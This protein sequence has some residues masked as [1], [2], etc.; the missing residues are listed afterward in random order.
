MNYP[1]PSKGEIWILKPDPLRKIQI[2]SCNDDEQVVVKYKDL[3][4]PSLSRRPITY[5]TL[6]ES[7]FLE[8]SKVAPVVDESKLC[9]MKRGA[10]YRMRYPS[11]AERGRIVRLL[12]WDDQTIPGGGV[13][14]SDEGA[15]MKCQKDL[16]VFQFRRK[17]EMVCETLAQL[18]DYYIKGEPLVANEYITRGRPPAGHTR[19]ERDELAELRKRVKEQEAR[20]V[21]LEAIATG[22]VIPMNKKGRAG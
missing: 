8:G 17:W 15:E 3:G 9:F 5:R 10:C 21:R 4:R 14:Y 1:T 7:W 18:P 16:S 6:R 22:N 19:Q 20:L 2:V 12:Q 13:G 11:D